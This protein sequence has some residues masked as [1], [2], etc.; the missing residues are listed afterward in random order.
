M[1]KG[2]EGLEQKRR[3]RASNSRGMRVE[4][5]PEK[6]EMMKDWK[7]MAMSRRKTWKYER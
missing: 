6:S 5:K 3:M 1:V 7:R 4:K 2:G